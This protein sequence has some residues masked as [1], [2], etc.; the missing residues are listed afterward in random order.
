[1]VSLAPAF[2][3][4]YVR[5]WRDMARHI[6]VIWRWGGGERSSVLPPTPNFRL[7]AI[8]YE[9]CINFFGLRGESWRR[10]E[11]SIGS[12]ESEPGAEKVTWEFG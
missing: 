4:R 2:T 12:P 3:L 10:G 7:V 5:P 1:M 9:R 11:F 6:P 8:R